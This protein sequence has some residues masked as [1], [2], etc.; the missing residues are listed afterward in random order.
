VKARLTPY[1]EHGRSKDDPALIKE[2]KKNGIKEDMLERN[3][4]AIITVK[5]CGVTKNSVYRLPIRQ[6][7]N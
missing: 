4:D 1:K 3:R 5:R 2:I 6:Q 7:N